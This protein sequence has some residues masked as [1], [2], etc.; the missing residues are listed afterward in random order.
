MSGF[1]K[2]MSE[3]PGSVNT[4]LG[5]FFSRYRIAVIIK[6]STLL[7]ID[8]ISVRLGMS[9]YMRADHECAWGPLV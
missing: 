1:S 7:V 6:I 5:S 3:N 8:V 2:F 9:E 4:L